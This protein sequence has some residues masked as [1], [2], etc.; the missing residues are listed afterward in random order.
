MD[1][2][3][4]SAGDPCERARQWSVDIG[5]ALRCDSSALLQASKGCA[6]VCLLR[7]TRPAVGCDHARWLC[8]LWQRRKPP[9]LARGKL[10]RADVQIET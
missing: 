7:R 9:P 2:L 1:A 10:A 6:M 8:W 4:D 5:R 3:R